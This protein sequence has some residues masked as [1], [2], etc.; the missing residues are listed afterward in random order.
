MAVAVWF[1]PVLVVV[2]F[3][4]SLIYLIWIRNTERYLR[5]PY[6]RLL[7]IFAYGAVISVIIAIVIEG[8]LLNL[9]NLNLQRIYQILGENQNLTTI[10][11]ALIIA[12]F[13][14][15]AAKSL[16]V[17]TS[18]KRMRDIEDGIIYGAAAG[19]GFAATENLL[20]ESDAF[21][22]A[23]AS[24]LIATAVV[25]TFSSALLHATASSVFGLGIARS[26]RQ[27]KRLLPYYLGAVAIHSAFNFAAS[28]G[29]L[30]QSS[31]GD[32][33]Y[34]IGLVAAAAFAVGGITYMR[35]KIRVLD[36]PA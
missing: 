12:P 22:T 34:L 25:R 33:A 29:I 31:I 18:R 9:L 35:A 13:V 26:T 7:T 10:V 11:L 36:T 5:E 27:G 4:P 23:G 3:V 14:E 30:Y 1:L 8:L 17:F 32:A 15:E 20:Y 2:A 24:A 19:L 16:G 6:Y 21:F 28:F